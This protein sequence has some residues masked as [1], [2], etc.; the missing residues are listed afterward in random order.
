MY[1]LFYT[2]GTWECAKGYLVNLTGLTENVAENV[3]HKGSNAFKR[4]VGDVFSRH[5]SITTLSICWNKKKK[6][7]HNNIN[8]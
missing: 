1:I 8:K 4:T 3:C 2:E 5:N 7:N 6:N